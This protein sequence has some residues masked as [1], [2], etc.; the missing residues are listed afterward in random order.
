LA[1]KE[2]SVCLSVIG[3]I[4]SGALVILIFK[5]PKV[6]FFNVEDY[7]SFISEFPS[8]RLL[9]PVVNAE[10]AK[11]CAESIWIELYGPD[12]LDERPYKLSYDATNK[13][14]LVQGNIRNFF[15]S[16]KGGTSHILIQES[17]GK[18]LAV[19]HDK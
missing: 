12:V 11:T 18:V 1:S 16:S 8:D 13:I 15:G 14:W 4:F 3:F 10:K 5:A 9:G 7:S 6:N 19:W 2:V 17:D